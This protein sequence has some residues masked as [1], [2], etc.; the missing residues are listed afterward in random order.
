MEENTEVA[1]SIPVSKSPFKRPDLVMKYAKS[2]DTG[3]AVYDTLQILC[4]VTGFATMMLA[5]AGLD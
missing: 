5:V 1:Q 4:I 2:T 3:D